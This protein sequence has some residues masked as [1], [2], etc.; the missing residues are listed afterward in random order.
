MG[1]V[2]LLGMAGNA[3]AQDPVDAAV[4]EGVSLREQGQDEEALAVF[5]RAYAEHGTP[6]L[7]AQI[8][9]AEH[10]LGRFRL[11]EEHLRSVQASSSDPWIASHA[12]VIA[13]SLEAIGARL[14]TLEITGGVDGATIRING[15]VRGTLPEAR[16]LRVEAGT[17][18]LEVLAGGYF[19]FQRSVEVVGGGSARE[20]I[21]LIVQGE[22][23][24]AR[25][26][27]E[28]SSAPLTTTSADEGG[29][30]D[31]VAGWILFGISAAIGVAGGILVGVA[32]AD[33]SAVENAP[34][35]S[36]WA[37]VADQYDRSEALSVAGFVGLGVG[38]VG[39]AV[40]LGWALGSG[41]GASDDTAELRVGPGHLSVR[42][43]FP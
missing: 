12:E 17:V 28:P 38:V 7:L 24:P 8:G 31:G 18:V 22:D 34:D 43:R 42:G 10:A 20:T 41:G 32:V 23:P 11:A 26:T 13:E 5:E 37:D 25:P 9:F 21:Q 39:M 3:T 16:R 36:A 1:I 2:V 4:R 40:G 14:G 30:G 35:D 6:R 15:D 33:V 29:G 27:T 19:P